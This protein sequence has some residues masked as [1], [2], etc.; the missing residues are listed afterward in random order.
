MRFGIV[1]DPV[2]HSRSPAMHE[3]GFRA[4]GIDAVYEFLPTPPDHFDRIIDG[5]RSG[6]L[7]GVNVTMPHKRAAFDAVDEHTVDAQRSG[8]VNTIVCRNGRLVGA[9]TD[10]GGITD[11]FDTARIPDL[12][13]V[14]VL[15]SGGAS[16]SAVVALCGR[17]VYVSARNPA[18]ATA[19]LDRVQCPGVVVRWGEGVAGSAIVNATPIGMHGESL[20]RPVLGVASGLVDMAY[21]PEETPA[22]RAIRRGGLPCADGLDVLVGQ[23]IGAFRL[24]TGTT[25]DRDILTTAARGLAGE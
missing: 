13:P 12:A 1:G 15:G 9:N 8:S 14:L 24:F 18:A 6:R 10:V 25:P 22:C 21:G 23:A 4:L 3:A 16:A 17:A 5:L 19:M 2:D 11:A 20:P 7:D